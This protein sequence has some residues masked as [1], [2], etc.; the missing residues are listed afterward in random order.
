MAT[1][2][3]KTQRDAKDAHE[4]VVR[5]GIDQQLNGAVS[6][7]EA[8]RYWL[9]HLEAIPHEILAD[10]LAYHLPTKQSIEHNLMK[11]LLRTPQA[12]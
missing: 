6:P 10:V 1:Q 8:K 4:D 11:A 7:N 3:P 2:E 12:R 9:A 5:N